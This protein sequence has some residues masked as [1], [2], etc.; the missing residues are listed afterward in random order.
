MRDVCALERGEHPPRY[1]LFLGFLK[2]GLLGFGG[3]AAWAYRVI[4]L[5][6]RW[7]SDAEYAALLGT[8]QVLPGANTLNAAVMIGDRFRGPSGAVVAVLGLMTMPLAIV[9]AIG[10]VFEQIRAVP[11][12]RAAIDG[13]AMAA[14]GVVVG[15]ALRMARRLR[16]DW[17][18][19]LFGGAIFVAVGIFQV[20]LVRA[21]LVLGSLS[22]AAAYFRKGA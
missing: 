14:A 22:I 2:I 21:V 11:D 12:V 18:A 19:V 9:V 17:A 1:A 15:M 13:V 16:L 4:V 20:S 6:R 5:E 8:S 3:V 7:L 10:T